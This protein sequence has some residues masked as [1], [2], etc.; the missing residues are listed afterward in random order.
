VAVS[1]ANTPQQQQQQHAAR[2]N[3]APYAQPGQTSC[4]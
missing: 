4:E 2:G 3:A 1:K